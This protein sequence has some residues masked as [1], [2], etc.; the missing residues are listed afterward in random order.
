MTIKGSSR[1]EMDDFSL[2]GAW[3]IEDS[4]NIIFRRVNV[5]SGK[6]S[7][8]AF[9]SN[10]QNSSFYDCEIGNIDPGDG[11]EIWPSPNGNNDTLLFDGLWIHDLTRNNDPTYHQDGVQMISGNNVRFNRMRMYNVST[12]GFYT[13][14]DIPPGSITNLTVENSWFGNIPQGYYAMTLR[15]SGNNFIIR[16]NTFTDAVYTQDVTGVHFIGNFFAGVRRKLLRLPGAQ[17]E[18]GGIQL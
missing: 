18:R 16:N 2:T 3:D 11:L 15:M 1:I 13:Q 10:T 8:G 14:P 6:G 17:R 4:N 12:Q 5:T 9:V 7:T